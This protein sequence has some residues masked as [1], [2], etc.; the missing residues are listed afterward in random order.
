MK[1]RKRPVLSISSPVIAKALFCPARCGLSGR[2]APVVLFPA[3]QQEY[4]GCN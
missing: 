2:I 4:H 1:S 3:R